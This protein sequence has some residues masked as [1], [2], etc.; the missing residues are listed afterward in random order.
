MRDVR[1]KADF[2]D[3]MRPVAQQ[4]GSQ[5]R[6]EVA[7][8]A[9]MQVDITTRLG[10]PVPAT[11]T[12]ISSLDGLLSG[13][14]RAGTLVVISG[15]EGSGKTSFALLIAY[16]AARSKAAALFTSASLDETEIMARLAA[17]AL[18]RE[19]PDVDTAY[20]DIWNGQ[21]WQDPIVRKP[22]TTA[23]E[24]VVQKVGGNLHLYRALPFES[25]REVERRVAELWGR[26]ERVVLVVDDLEALSGEH[27]QSE[28][29]PSLEDRVLRAA[30]DLRRIAEMGCAVVA[31]TSPRT[32][33]VVNQAATLSA[34]LRRVSV[35]NLKLNTIERT[36]GA[37]AID[38]V[39]NK[40]R[41]GATG[42]VPLKFVGGASVFVE[43]E[44]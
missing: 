35:P 20:G 21:A 10:A 36:L 2:R 41:H 34:A 31:T 29:D 26:T 7:S 14:L 33:R 1:G 13:G 5:A 4:P 12:G 6:R 9:S 44:S 23:V 38:L 40:N 15:P 30:Y 37:R 22:V 42:V 3:R 18:H 11:P 28:E 16:M 27:A 19:W 32:Q 17:R 39:V 8:L 24:T 43:R 25:T